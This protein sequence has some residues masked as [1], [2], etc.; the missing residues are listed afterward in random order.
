MFQPRSCKSSARCAVIIFIIDLHHAVQLIHHHHQ[1]GHNSTTPQITFSSQSVM[2]DKLHTAVPQSYTN[3]LKYKKLRQKLVFNQK[4][5]ACISCQSTTSQTIWPTVSASTKA[6]HPLTARRVPNK[7][8]ALQWSQPPDHSSKAK[9][10]T[11]N[12]QYPVQKIHPSDLGESLSHSNIWCVR[13]EYQV[14]SCSSQLL[15]CRQW[16]CGSV[17]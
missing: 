8:T 15:K 13:S 9:D 10:W 7:L 12:Q 17:V 4:P 2:F 1:Q 16:C 14:R 11:T 6:F 5:A 3:V